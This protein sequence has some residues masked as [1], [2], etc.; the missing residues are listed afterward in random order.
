MDLKIQ[1]ASLDDLRILQE[2]HSNLFNKEHD[3]YDK[4][5]DADWGKS[6][7]GAAYFKDRITGE[8]HCVF[9]ARS[10][11]RII[12]YLAGGLV[13]LEHI[14]YLGTTA[15]LES[16]FVLRE[17]RTLGVGSKLISEFF[18]WCQDKKVARL[19]VEVTDLNKSA[20]DFYLKNGFKE[21]TEILNYD[22]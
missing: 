7:S 1:K 10:E 9:I 2:L 13:N 15:E 21:Y 6:S 22:F 12:G 19:W 3:E 4:L 8:D 18:K 5:I 11:D 20:K 14:A 16:I 17:Y